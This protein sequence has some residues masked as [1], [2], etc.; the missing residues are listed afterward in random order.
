[1]T[2]SSQPNAPSASILRESIYNAFQGLDLTDSITNMNPQ[3]LR[4]ADNSNI[5]ISGAIQT[6]EGFNDSFATDWSGYKITNGIEYKANDSTTQIVIYGENNVLGQAALAIATTSA[7]PFISTLNLQRPSLVQFSS[8]LFFFNGDQNILYNGTLTNQVGITQVAVNPSDGGDIAGNL[9]NG[10]EYGWTYTY[11]NSVTGAESSPPDVAPIYGV[12]TL[13][14]TPSGGRRIDVTPGDPATADTIRLYRTAANSPI[15]FLDTTAAI[16]ATSIDSTIADAGLGIELEQDNTMLDTWGFPNYAVSANNRIFCGGFG[17]PNESRIRFSKISEEGAMPQS[18]QASGFADC[19][20]LQGLN[21]AILGMGLALQTPIILKKYSI[22][23]LDVSGSFTSE[24]GSDTAIYQYNEISRGITS[25]SHWAITNVYNNMIWLGKDNI[26]MTDGVNVTPIATQISSFIKTLNF[27]FP[28][29]YSAVNDLKNRKLIFSAM[30]NGS[31]EPNCCIVGSYQ[32]Y[33]N[34][35]WTIWRQGPDFV[36]WP[37]VQAGCL[38]PITQSDGTQDIYFGNANYNGK[39]YHLSSTLTNDDGFPIY[40]HVQDYPTSYGISEDTKLF[41]KDVF[42]IQGNGG[43]YGV[44]IS[45][46]YDL[47]TL[48]VETQTISVQNTTSLWDSA[49]WDS[50]KWANEGP[51]RLEFNPHTKAYFKQLDFLN[52]SLD[53]P[54]TIY[55]WTK[56]ARPGEFK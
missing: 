25:V 31:S 1:M 5:Q 48:P 39:F 4:I 23:R 56:A 37:G 49:I 8:L 45:S 53:Q 2:I 38:L 36:A 50:S 21:D 47:N 15:L 30:E 29:K 6:R 20:S 12:L 43:N 19:N 51:L 18:F 22:G 34:F 9:V 3:S 26:Y 54:L 7:T 41:F 24:V 32:Q 16:T 28:Q 42:F 27:S 11:Y 55:G 46:V 10:A 35:Y 52:S 13:V 33:P 17:S 14:V 40:Y 44:D